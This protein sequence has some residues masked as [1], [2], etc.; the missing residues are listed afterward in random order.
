MKKLLATL[1]TTALAVSIVACGGKDAVSTETTES[2]ISTETSAEN[3][4]EIAGTTETETA[5]VEGD[6]LGQTLLTAFKDMLTA[7]PYMAPQEIANA[8]I[9]H[10]AILFEGGITPVKPGFLMGFKAD[11][12]GF[13]EGVNFAPMIGTIPFTGYVFSLAEDADAEAFIATLKENADL[14]WNVCTEAEEI[15]IEKAENTNK[16]FFLM[17]PLKLDNEFTEEA[18]ENTE[19]EN[20]ETTTESITN[21]V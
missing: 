13:E 11:I 2:V 14:R 3:S 5:E 6:T 4:A 16:V 20:N 9:E 17:S 18:T 19:I 15:I 21:N 7:N 8:I 10:E 12:T 1:L